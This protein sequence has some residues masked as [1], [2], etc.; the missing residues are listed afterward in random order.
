MTTISIHK[1]SQN[2]EKNFQEKRCQEVYQSNSVEMDFKKQI[3]PDKE[4]VYCMGVKEA[5]MHDEACNQTCKVPGIRFAA[6]INKNGRKIAGGFSSKITPLEKDQQKME[7]LFMEITLDFSMRK[8]YDDSLGSIH[9][10]VSYRD[11]ANIITIPYQDNL[12]LL[13]VEPEVD[14]SKVI[15]IAYQKIIAK[16]ITEVTLQ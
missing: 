1:Q 16:K 2:M 3:Q 10:I 8:D 14:V 4:R 6:I 15:R 9:A 5:S 12:I 11:K 7:M 13:S